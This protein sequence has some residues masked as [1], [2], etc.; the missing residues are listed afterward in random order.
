[1]R[2]NVDF[3]VLLYRQM[4]IKT[5]LNTTKIAYELSNMCTK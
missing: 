1:M 5:K 2:T 3:Y 4:I